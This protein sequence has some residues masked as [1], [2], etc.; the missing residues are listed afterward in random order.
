MALPLAQRQSDVHLLHL[1]GLAHP[2]AVETDE[3]GL[4]GAVGQGEALL[5]GDLRL[6]MSQQLAEMLTC[7]HQAAPPNTSIS[8]NTQAGEACPTRI[9]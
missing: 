3:A 6:Q 8:A 2:P 5:A 7:V 9:T 1:P 4:L